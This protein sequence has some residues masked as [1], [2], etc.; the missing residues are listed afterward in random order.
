MAY[1]AHDYYP[2]HKKAELPT[3]AARLFL[4]KTI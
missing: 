3:L 2:P 1:L 4:T